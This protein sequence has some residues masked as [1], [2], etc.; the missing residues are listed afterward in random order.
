MYHADKTW[1]FKEVVQNATFRPVSGLWLRGRQATL[2]TRQLVVLELSI[3]EVR[4]YI[5]PVRFVD[6]RQKGEGALTWAV[7]YQLV[8]TWADRGIRKYAPHFPVLE[9]TRLKLLWA[10]PVVGTNVEVSSPF[11]QLVLVLLCLCWCAFLLACRT[12]R[13]LFSGCSLALPE[14][15]WRFHSECLVWLAACNRLAQEVH[16]FVMPRFF[17]RVRVLLFLQ[18]FRC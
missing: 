18:S 7:G 12:L 1:K 6:S 16:E 10:V 17:A 13:D 15:L 5:E 2:K 8:E 11:V 3:D 4:H 14:C 9:R